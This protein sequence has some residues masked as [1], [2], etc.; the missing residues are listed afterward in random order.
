MKIIAPYVG[1][2][3]L[4]L[5]GAPEIGG[6]VISAAMFRDWKFWLFGIVAFAIGVRL[7]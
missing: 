3:W 6:L 7:G 5:V 4:A 1:G 2:F